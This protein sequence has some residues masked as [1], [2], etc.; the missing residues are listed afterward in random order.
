MASAAPRAFTAQGVASDGAGNLYVAD[1]S[2]AL[3][4][5][6][7][8]ATSAVTTLAGA[9][10]AYGFQDDIGSAA[11]FDFVGKMVWDGAGKLLISDSGVVVRS[12]DLATA[13]VTT[14]AGSPQRGSTDG[15][16]STAG[17]SNLLRMTVDGAGNLYMADAGNS[18]IRHMVM[19]T[20]AVTTV[21]G[22]AAQTAS[23]DGLG[24]SA[25]FAHPSSLAY[26]GADG[27]Y[28][29]DPDNHAVRKISL[30][31]ARVTTVVGTPA[32]SGI[33]L[34]PLPGSLSAPYGV[35]VTR[36][37]T[38]VITDAFENAILIAR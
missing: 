7:V 17:F 8:L 15:I 31:D 37:G 12:L 22:Q 3:I 30:T 28:V 20:R 6:I 9:A 4:R 23:S 24:N 5:R 18:E 13:A 34:G 25:R 10:L 29:A 11:R 1:T 38:R 27:L 32:S 26:D 19:A 36:R 21:V 14:L 33:A 2:N 16:G 35:C